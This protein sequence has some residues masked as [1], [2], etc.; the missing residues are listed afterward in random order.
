MGKSHHYVPQFYLRQFSEYMGLKE[1]NVFNIRRDEFFSKVPIKGQACRPN[2]YGDDGKIENALSVMETQFSILCKK[3]L[4]EELVEIKG[5][6][7]FLIH[8][9]IILSY[10]RTKKVADDTDKSAEELVRF[11]A[12]HTSDSELIKEHIDTIKISL[13]NP[14]AIALS[15]LEPIS[16]MIWDLDIKVICNK[17]DRGLITSDSPVCLYNSY[18]E[19]K[20]YL[21]S[22]RGLALKGTVLVLPMSK[23]KL[24]YLYDSDVYHYTGKNNNIND[25]SHIDSF[26]KL[27][28]LNADET[29]FYPSLHLEKWIRKYN[30]ELSSFIK[31][32]RRV[33]HYA[34]L[35]H[36]DNGKKRYDVIKDFKEIPQDKD[37]LIHGEQCNI[38]ANIA[39]PHLQ[40]KDFYRNK[41]LEHYPI[42]EYCALLKNAR[43]D[44]GYIDF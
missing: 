8:F 24:I 23:D 7:K 14:A 21:R 2:F 27:Q 5:E 38:Y 31:K 30:R 4:N 40:I 12:Y 3:I 35:A 1:I 13:N 18:L 22:S 41:Q 42:R 16:S 15:Q 17:T 9:Y 26:N 28:I 33:T 37:L 34:Y 39:L 25:R 19:S 36:E 29:I 11:L 10:L 6:D 32:E 44:K 43:G 20:K